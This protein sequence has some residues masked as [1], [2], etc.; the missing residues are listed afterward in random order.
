[1]KKHTKHNIISS[2]IAREMFIRLTL[3]VVLPVTVIGAFLVKYSYDTLYNKSISQI[4]SD[5]LRVKSLLVDCFIS[6]YNIADELIND[7]NLQE[8]LAEEIW[9]DEPF[10]PQTVYS[11]IEAILAGNTSISSLHIYST[12]PHRTAGTYISPATEDIIAECFTKADIPASTMWGI[13]PSVNRNKDNPEL[14]LVRSFPLGDSKY[15]A[16]LVITI[17]S[18][19]L[20]NR[21]QNNSLSTMLTVNRSN[22]FFS[23]IRS[24]QGTSMPIEI[25]YTQKYFQQEGYFDYQGKKVLGCTSAQPIYGTNDIL[26]ICTMDLNARNQMLTVSLT[27]SLITFGVIAVVLIVIFIYAGYFSKRILALRTSM[28]GVRNGNYDEIIA[29]LKGDD[30]LTETFEDLKLLVEDIKKRDTLM[31]ESQL[32]EQELINEQSKMQYKL[33]SNQINPHFIYNTLETIRMLALESDAGQVADA[34]LLLAK[35]MRYVLDNTIENSTT[36]DREL[37]YVLVYLKIQQI[38]FEDRLEYTVMTDPSIDLHACHILPILLQ[39]IVENA[40]IHGLES[41]VHKV[42]ISIRI[43]RKDEAHMLISI[44]DNGKGMTPE[45]LTALNQKLCEKN[46]TSASSIGLYNIQSRIHLHYGEEYNLSIESAPDAGTTV[47]VLL[48]IT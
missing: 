41:V 21:I 40:V 1:M 38:R 45:E 32:K 20:R 28:K 31:Y 43:D 39:P 35:A 18:N 33:L 6:T 3:I 27:N 25:N 44:S 17:S 24:L 14:T 4:S 13:Y 36:L 5:N 12:N 10:F 11:R 7:E 8:Y 34:T 19:Y 30:E 26:Y 22:I 15:Q 42:L 47:T 46:R 23:T 29:S 2:K 37:D 9:N 16:I 48:P